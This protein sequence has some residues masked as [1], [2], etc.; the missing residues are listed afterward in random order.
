MRSR[1]SG[2]RRRKGGRTVG[3]RLGGEAGG[4]ANVSER[5]CGLRACD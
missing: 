4:G 3:V 5:S 2:G 1:T